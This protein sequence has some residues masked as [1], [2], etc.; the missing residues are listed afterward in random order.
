MIETKEQLEIL[1]YG[2]EEEGLLNVELAPCNAKGKRK[3]AALSN[4]V[5]GHD[6]E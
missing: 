2:G 5:N 4:K 6:S 1:D 3:S